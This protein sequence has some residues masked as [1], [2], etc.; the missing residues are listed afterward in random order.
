MRGIQTVQPPS[1][2]Q[3]ACIKMGGQVQLAA[4]LGVTQQAVSFWVQQGHAPLERV[5]VIAKLTGIRPRALC[6][7]ELV[8]L[9]QE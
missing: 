9:I 6:D 7:P 3:E 5:P 8:A 1:G 2:I 4:A